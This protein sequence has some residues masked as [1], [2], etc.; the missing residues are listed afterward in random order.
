MD[1]VFLGERKIEW[2]DVRKDTIQTFF[3]NPD[4][5]TPILVGQIAVYHK[6]GLSEAE[7]IL[8]LLKQEGLIQEVSGEESQRKFGVSFGYL[9][10]AEILE[11]RERVREKLRQL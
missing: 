3:S 4:L 6:C 11:E 7:N 2:K 8:N 1:R 9:P 5:D 10:S